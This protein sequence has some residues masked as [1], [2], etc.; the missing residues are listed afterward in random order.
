MLDTFTILT[1]SGVVLWSRTYS[2]VPPLVINTFISHVFIEERTLTNK[3]NTV[4]TSALSDAV[5]AP[6]QADQHTLKW[7]LVKDVGVIFVVRT[8]LS[9]ERATTHACLHSKAKETESF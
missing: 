9:F 3:P 5:N 1:T 2:R 8:P 6:Y 7:A 4:P